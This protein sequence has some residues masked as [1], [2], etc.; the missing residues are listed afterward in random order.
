[1]GRF[2]SIIDGTAVFA[3]PNETHRSYCEVVRLDVES[4]IS[5]HFGVNIPLRLVVDEDE[6]GPPAGGTPPDQDLPDL[7][8]PEV[9]AVE[10]VPAEDGPSPAE[11]LK[12]VFPGAEEV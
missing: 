11:R 10:T 1:M 9:F 7:L 4:A 6:V 2:V 5:S 12:K 3:L 8:D